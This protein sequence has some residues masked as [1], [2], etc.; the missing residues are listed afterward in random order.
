[1]VAAGLFVFILSKVMRPQKWPESD[2]IREDRSC[3]Q[4]IVSLAGL[5]NAH[6]LGS[7][8]PHRRR[9]FLWAGSIVM[10]VAAPMTISLIGAATRRACRLRVF[11]LLRW[12][13]RHSK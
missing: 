3:P 8:M 11:R 2:Q 6:E 12:C 1:M 13:R 5:R 4:S 9:F 10:G 7:A